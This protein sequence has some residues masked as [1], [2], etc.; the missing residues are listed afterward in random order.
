[1]EDIMFVKIHLLTHNLNYK[2]PCMEMCIVYPT[3]SSIAITLGAWRR[4]AQWCIGICNVNYIIL[5]H[6]VMQIWLLQ[7]HKYGW[8]EFSLSSEQETFRL[9]LLCQNKKICI[10]IHICAITT[11]SSNSIL[12]LYKLHKANCIHF[13]LNI[14][15]YLSMS[16][17]IM[18][19]W[20]KS[21]LSKWIWGFGIKFGTLMF[22]IARSRHVKM[23]M[24]NATLKRLK[25][26]E[27]IIHYK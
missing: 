23:E 22:L 11:F 13:L 1:M 14:Y 26:R 2:Y 5:K 7:L 12:K 20:P 16:V 24:I 19:R 6:K 18:A 25:I 3:T 8:T 10:P 27:E 4:V 15:C 21:G 17:T 9:I